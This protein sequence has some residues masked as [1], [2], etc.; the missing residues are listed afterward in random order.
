[1]DACLQHEILEDK[2]VPAKDFDDP[3]ISWIFDELPLGPM[4]QISFSIS[5]LQTHR[6]S[7]SSK[8][9][10]LLSSQASHGRM[11]QVNLMFQSCNPTE[12]YPSKFK[13]LYQQGKQNSTAASGHVCNSH[14]AKVSKLPSHKCFFE[15]TFACLLFS[16]VIVGCCFSASFCSVVVV[17][18]QIQPN[19]HRLRSL[20]ILFQR[21][22]LTGGEKV[23]RVTL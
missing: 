12:M 14:S 17:S 16:F 22:H 19:P 2:T 8:A 21:F 6:W 5:E 9:P 18:F 13:I 7:C 10:P 1:M 11:L 23:T 15:G 4:M 3:K 20:Q